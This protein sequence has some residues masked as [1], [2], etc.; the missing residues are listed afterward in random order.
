VPVNGFYEWEVQGDQRIPYFVQVL[1]QPAMLLATVFQPVSPEDIAKEQASKTASPQMGF[2][3][4]DDN[5]EESGPALP[6]FTGD[7]AVV[8]TAATGTM[9]SIHERTP[10]MLSPDNA[11]RWLDS[12]DLD[13]IQ[14]MLVPDSIRNDGPEC[15]APA[16]DD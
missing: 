16:D 15:L 7:F 1:D 12:D 6:S 5:E 10:V 9:A 11:A 4:E 2:S 14:S 3:F 13:E 8:T